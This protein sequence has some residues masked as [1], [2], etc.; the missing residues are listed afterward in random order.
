MGASKGNEICKKQE[1][2]KAEEIWMRESLLQCT[3]E[4]YVSVINDGSIELDE[5]VDI[6]VSYLGLVD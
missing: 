3:E 1:C 4:Q 2:M 6:V 5:L